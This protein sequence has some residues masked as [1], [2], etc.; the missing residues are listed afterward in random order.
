MPT[1][2]G[3]QVGPT[4]YGLMGLTWRDPATPEEQAIEALRAALQTGM[5]LWNG[6]EFYGTPERNSLTLLER[7]FARYPG[8]AERVLLCVKGGLNTS[9]RGADGSPENTR[10]S[11]DACIALL[12]GR[13]KID[14]FECARRDPDVPLRTTLEV[15]DKE[16]YTGKIGGISL[17]EVRAETIHEAVKIT[18][19]CAVEVELSLFST[20][21]LSNGVA[22]ACAQYDIPLVAY[23][24]VGRGMLT[25]QIKCAAD[26]K[27][28]MARYPRFQGANLEVNLR[29][30]AGVE[31]LAARKGVTPAQLAIAWTRRLATWRRGAPGTIIPIPGA[32]TAPRVRENGTLVEIADEEMREL[33]EMLGGLRL[34]RSNAGKSRRRIQIEPGRGKI[35]DV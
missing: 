10:R 1:L 2:V 35:E 26:V 22:D 13:K 8:D 31:A 33:D 25:G 18:K 12:K 15:I 30:A 5:N 24:P 17:S 29:L 19:I 14:L 11:I 7:Y 3:R 27:P 4:G 28:H 20:E 23:S 21:I 6:G 34:R 32:T 9:T 16:W